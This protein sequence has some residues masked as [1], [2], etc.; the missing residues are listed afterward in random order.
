MCLFVN[1]FPEEEIAEQRQGSVVQQVPEPV[2]NVLINAIDDLLDGL[3]ELVNFENALAQEGAFVIVNAQMAEP[4]QP[5]QLPQANNDHQQQ[6]VPP[7]NDA[8]VHHINGGPVGPQ[9]NGGP[10]RN[11]AQQNVANNADRGI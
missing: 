4:H 1:P 7:I 11:P 5:N 3:N 9:P 10:Q 8:Q 6:Q 2:N